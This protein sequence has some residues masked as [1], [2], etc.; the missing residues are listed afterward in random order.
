MRILTGSQALFDL[1]VQHTAMRQLLRKKDIRIRQLEAAQPKRKLKHAE[2]SAS[3]LKH[4]NTIALGARQYTTL[5][6]VF[7]DENLLTHTIC[8]TIDPTSVARY[9]SETADK[10]AKIAEIFLY[11]PS[12]IGTG[13]IGSPWFRDKVRNYHPYAI[14]LLV[15]PDYTQTVQGKL[16]SKKV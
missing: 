14:A 9:A 5:C 12:L 3:F 4:E 10:Q 15:T 8:P 6:S 13:V 7:L 16:S 2:V 11:L 1:Q